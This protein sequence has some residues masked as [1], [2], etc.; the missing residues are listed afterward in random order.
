MKS[1]DKVKEAKNIIKSWSFCYHCQQRIPTQVVT[2]VI[3][4]IHS[5]KSEFV[6]I[7]KNKKRQVIM[8][9]G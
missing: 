2:L 8:K 6:V 9:R 5:R 4:Y 7:F 3:H 1:V